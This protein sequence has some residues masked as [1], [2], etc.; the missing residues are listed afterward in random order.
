MSEITPKMIDEREAA[1]D[2]RVSDLNI[3][4]NQY[5][6]LKVMDTIHWYEE[7]GLETTDLLETADAILFYDGQRLFYPL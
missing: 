2:A 7:F 6:F 4:E 1:F 3:T 5:R